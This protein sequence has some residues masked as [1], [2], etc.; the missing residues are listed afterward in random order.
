MFP[1]NNLHIVNDI[2]KLAWTY[3]ESQR[4]AVFNTVS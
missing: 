2:R 1:V 3:N 4:N